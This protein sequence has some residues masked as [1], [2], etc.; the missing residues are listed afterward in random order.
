MNR[1][2][3]SKPARKPISLVVAVIVLAFILI[4]SA[5]IFLNTFGQ[6][7]EGLL[8]GEKEDIRTIMVFL[9]E[10]LQYLAQI[11]DQQQIQKTISSLGV[12]VDI[13][14]ALLLDEKDRVIAATRVD[15]IGHK[16]TDLF[17]PR[18]I[19]ALK[20]RATSSKQMLTNNLWQ[21]ADKKLMYAIAPIVLGRSS[22]GQLR[23]DKIGI[24]F[25][26]V[27]QGW[28]DENIKYSLLNTTGI[29]FLVILISGIA[30]AVYFN[31]YFSQRIKQLRDATKEF[32]ASAADSEVS[33]DII[34]N[35]E[36]T[37]LGEAFNDMVVHIKKQNNDILE[38]EEDLS[39]TLY[40]I[41]DGVITTDK[42]GNVTRMNPVAEQ[43]TGW[44]LA[45]AYGKSVKTVF[46]IVDATT[47]QEINNPVEKVIATGE[48]VYLSNHTTL[49][50][51]DGREYQIS[52]S[53]AP[54]R[55]ENNE[56]SGMV[57]IFNDVTEQYR[58]RQSVAKSKR[59]L[60]A[61]MDN[62]PAVI[63]TKDVDGR[64]LF[65]NNKFETLFKVSRENIVGKTDYDIFPK[66]HADIF[67]ENDLAVIASKKTVETEEIAPHDDGPHSYISN[68]FPLFDDE[69]NIYAVCG[70]ST[71][72][73]ERI[74]A[75]E[76]LRH[77]QRMDALGK[78]TG[79]VAHDYNNMLGI[80]LGYSE[81]LEEAVKDQPKLSEYVHEIRHAGERGAQLTKRLLNFSRSKV[82]KS[83]YL[84]INRLLH[85]SEAMLKKTL[86]ARI[87]IV[88]NLEQDLWAVWIDVSDLEDAIVNMCINASHAMDGHGKL[89]I[90]TKNIHIN[91]SS[92]R[93]L[94]LV[95]G[96]YVLLSLTD[97][98]S[99]MSE[100]TKERLFD[101]FYSTKGERGTG[102]GLSQVYGFV[103]RSH[104]AIKVY[105]EEGHGSR[106]MLYF[107][108]YE[109]GDKSQN[110]NVVNMSNA[111]DLSGNETILIV[112]DEPVLLKLT[113]Q[114]LS[115]QGYHVIAA[116][117]AA[118]A[119]KEL[120]ANQVDLIISDI[121]MPDMD[122]YE[123]AA[124]V[125]K[126]YPDLK[127]QLASGFADDRR[128]KM[129]DSD[130]QENILQKPY[131]LQK[132]LTRIRELLDE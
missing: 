100:I 102:L 76:Q 101:P 113:S 117:C 51:K 23:S 49:I 59:D 14:K 78:L 3:V 107:P 36:I 110:N 2:A 25:I 72:I 111:N 87:E 43:M 121:I 105:S 75:N 7:K 24:L 9:Q 22:N 18:T 5:V 114:V 129:V 125:Q 65:I 71:D 84:D 39:V 81:M 88:M 66:E 112:D 91:A 62:S 37:D 122:G 90:E 31:I 40:S 89:T 61:I 35:D 47:R 38:R 19:S 26:E 53:A 116:N 70:I 131:N 97:T 55:N 118:Q 12:R 93:F 46:P 11:K 120:E 6:L 52:D 123:L 15:N 16:I 8:E 41:G 77:A 60:Q 44:I 45:D 94:D 68:K 128:N 98:G 4:Q 115:R 54:I 33:V 127:I 57:L 106:F 69:G 83:E 109:D 28:I 67:R 42:D 130:I 21:S 34:G 86:T 82:S 64:Y 96:D 13:K 63:Y 103:E 79:G 126:K 73:T 1:V 95:P 58:L 30:F 80:I 29:L 85:E 17:E 50:S 132:L 119:L 27:D 104:G 32:S 48:T 124:A 99:G 10:N 56:I 74:K 20:Q 108:R 92:E